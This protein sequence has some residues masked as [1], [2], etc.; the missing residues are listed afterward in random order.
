MQKNC[1]YLMKMTRFKRL[2]L[3]NTARIPFIRLTGWNT[4]ETTNRTS[5]FEFSGQSFQ[6]HIQNRRFNFNERIS[7]NAN[8]VLQ[9]GGTNES[10]LCRS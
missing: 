3:A 9:K 10:F 4:I 5:D 2:F 8:L 6:Q 7:R 1:S